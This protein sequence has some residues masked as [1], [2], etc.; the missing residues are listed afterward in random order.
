[1]KISIKT[2][3]SAPLNRVW[4]A[5]TTPE[6]ITQWNFASDDWCCP[7]AEIDLQAGGKFSYRMEAKDGSMGFDFMGTFASVQKPHAIDILLGDDRKVWLTF[8]ETDAGVEVE[9]S[10]EAED[11]NSAEMQRQGWQAILNN[12]KK[13][14]ESQS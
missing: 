2:T 11:E 12:F 1:M 3:V 5:W 6:D 7:S 8:A 10:F 14:V 4:E 13:H 9:E